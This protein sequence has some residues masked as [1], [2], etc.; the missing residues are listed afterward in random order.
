MTRWRVIAPVLAALTI[1]LMVPACGG[2]KAL[3]ILSVATGTVSVARPGSAKVDG[4]VGMRVQAGD[5]IESGNNSTAIITFFEGSTI[6]LKPGTSIEVVSLGA[7]RSGSTTVLLRQTLGG[8]VS[9]V[10][11]LTDAK[12]RYEIETPVAVAG[13]R[14]SIMLVDVAADG[15]TH[16]GNQAGKIV[17][18]AQGVE[19]EVPVG[20]GGLVKPGEPPQPELAH[21]DGRAEGGYSM[22]NTGRELGFAVQFSPAP[23]PFEIVK[24]RIFAW[25]PGTPAADSKFTLRIVAADRRILWEESFAYTRFTAEHA[26][27]EVDVPG[28]VVSDNFSVQLYAPTLGQGQG[29]F[30]GTDQSGPNRNSSMVLNWEPIAWTTD[31]PAQSDTN[32]MIR[33]V[34]KAP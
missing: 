4:K 14:G 8:T 6:E 33:L 7:A 5:V 3:T 27:V 25:M 24:A 30:I 29:P 13:V 26:W 10:V 1:A 12:S 18:V 32:W 20:G 31:R 16:V 34:G 19:L 28:I 15:T 17:V 21:D 2:S 9:R 22:G 23:V 11:K